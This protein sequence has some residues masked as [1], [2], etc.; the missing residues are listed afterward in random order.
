MYVLRLIRTPDKEYKSPR[1]LGVRVNESRLYIYIYK[2]ASLACAARL[3]DTLCQPAAPGVTLIN[4]NG[5]NISIYVCPTV[6]I[7]IARKITKFVNF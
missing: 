5:D 2:P 4:Y 1:S 6:I 7:D 3:A